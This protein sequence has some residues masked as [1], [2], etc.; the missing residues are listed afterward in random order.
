M[1]LAARD[2]C[3]DA[4]P[5]GIV[6][7]VGS[8]ASTMPTRLN[9]YGQGEGHGDQSVSF[10]LNSSGFDVVMRLL[11]DDGVS[12]RVNRSNLLNPSYGVTGI[13]SG[14]HAAFDFMVTLVYIENCTMNR[15]GN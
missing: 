5:K 4:G 6:N 1:C 2:H 13:C 12:S 8:D 15:F 10:G 9:K 3:K 7:N 11:I 14:A